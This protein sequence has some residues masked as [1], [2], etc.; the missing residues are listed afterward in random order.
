METQVDLYR[1]DPGIIR[2]KDAIQD[3]VIELCNL[4]EMKR[5]G[6][7]WIEHFGENE[8]IAGFSMSQPIETSLISGHFANETNNVYINIF[9][10]KLYDPY[11]A[12]A[13]TKTFFKAESLD[14]HI[15]L[16]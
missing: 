4:I 3:Y 2:S 12:A 8:R 6:D 11:V 1:C 9:S 14:I 7:T 13:F 15:V 16:R 5:Y 10:C